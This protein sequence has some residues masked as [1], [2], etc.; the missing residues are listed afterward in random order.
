MGGVWLFGFDIGF[1]RTP[2]NGLS[3]LLSGVLN[4][5]KVPVNVC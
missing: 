3:R 2:E 4:I 1:I 5:R